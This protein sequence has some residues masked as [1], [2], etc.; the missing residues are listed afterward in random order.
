MI[1]CG[2]ALAALAGGAVARRAMIESDYAA[3]L[4]IDADAIPAHPRLA[5]FAIARA[6]PLYGRDCAGCHGADLRGDPRLGAANLAD[7]DWLHGEGR[8]S[9][10]EQT[11]T[12]GIRSGD[13]KGRS[14]A[15]MPGYASPEP[16]GRYHIPPLAPADIRDTTAYILSLEGRPADPAS[17]ARGDQIFHGRGGCYDCHG[18]DGHGDGAIGAPNLADRIWLY[19]DGSPRAIFNSIAQGRA[20]ACPG[21]IGRLTPGEIRALAVFVHDRAARGPARA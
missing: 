19:G 7:G 20:G 3:L 9:D 17:A 14:L 18:A 21:W 4:R 8:I 10:I 6:A 15:S 12:H 11:L 2:L 16:Y 1:A 13:P 5:A